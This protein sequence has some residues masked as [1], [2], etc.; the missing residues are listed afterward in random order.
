MREPAIINSWNRAAM[1]RVRSFP[2]AT[3]LPILDTITRATQNA[4]A[5]ARADAWLPVEYSIELCDTLVDVLGAER[6]VEFW[7]DLVYDSWVGGLLEP[8]TN[9]LH[10]PGAA[11]E[12]EPLERRNQ[13]VLALA[14]AAW[15]ISTRDCGEIVVV[16]TD[17]A[18]SMRLEARDLPPMVRVSMGIQVLYAG[19]IKAML[20]FS[21]LSTHVEIVSSGDTLA[22][23]L[24]SKAE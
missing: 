23:A 6:A 15:S 4:I 10:T 18:G 14:P 20:A 13:G 8:L 19:A 5:R 2:D 9:T 24:T 1:R 11:A 16:A 17:E 12:D 21:Q 22:F 3:R 7:R